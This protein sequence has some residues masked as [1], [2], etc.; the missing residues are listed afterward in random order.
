MATAS[1]SSLEDQAETI[2]SDLREKP[3]IKDILDHLRA[4]LPEN[5]HYHSIQHTEDVLREAIVFSIHDGLEKEEIE[6]LAIGAAYHDAGFMETEFNNEKIGAQMAEDAM[7]KYN[8]YSENDISCVKDMILDTKLVPT[9]KGLKQIARSK[10]SK[11]LLD[12]DLSNFGRDDFFE[13][14]SLHRKEAGLDEET[15]LTR[16]FELLRNHAWLTQAAES[17]RENT[18][19]QN[20]KELSKLLLKLKATDDSMQDISLNL[21]RLAFLAKLP[22]LLN[23]SFDRKKVIEMTIQNL[24]SSLEAEAATVFLLNDANTELTFWALAG[25]NKLELEGKKMPRDKGIVGWVIDRKESLL[26]L[27]AANDPRFFSDIDKKGGFVTKNLICVPI[28]VRG[29]TPIGAIQVLNKRGDKAFKEDELLFVEQCAHQVALA[30]DNARLFEK[31]EK[32]KRLLE[33]VHKRKDE[34]I[35]VIAHEFRTPLGIIQGASDMLASGLLS[36]EDQIKE[37]QSSLQHGVERLTYLLSQVKELSVLTP[38]TIKAEQKPFKV[39]NVVNTISGKFSKICK[40]RSLEFETIV[41]DGIPDAKGDVELILICLNHLL[42][43][44]VRFTQDGGKIALNIKEGHGIVEFEVTDTGIGIE[45]S[46]MNLIFEKFYEVGSALNHSSGDYAFKSGGLG[47]GLSAVK[48]ILEA[49]G[50]SIEIESKVSQGST[51]RFCLPAAQEGG[52]S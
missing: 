40:D 34:M 39:E 31:V 52:N 38:E 8:G 23:S 7:R 22:L 11:Y 2:L 46:E 36:D 28:L 6:L 9:T 18:K 3:I 44:A 48:S 17:L 27:D 14:G 13:K 49:H 41:Q 10:L 43:N 29:D 47:L 19:Q 25:G 24:V 30:I 1:Q 42:A 20:L 26:I 32:R 33:T 15:Y 45:E 51:F 21:E 16:S 4:N 50:A 37:M 5:L 35:S 12:A